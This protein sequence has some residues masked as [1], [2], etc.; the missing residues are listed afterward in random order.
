MINGITLAAAWIGAKI[1]PNKPIFA[2]TQDSLTIAAP[3]RIA[4]EG[5]LELCLAVTL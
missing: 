5:A 1:F 2:N 4:I 3:V